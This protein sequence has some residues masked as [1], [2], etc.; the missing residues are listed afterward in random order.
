VTS[1]AWANDNR[2]IIYGQEDATTKRS[3]KIFRHALGSEQE[4]LLY[5][6]KDELYNVYTG[7]DAQ[8]RLHRRSLGQF[9][10]ER[11]ALPVGGSSG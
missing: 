6:E 5:E 4:E 9:D 8:Q 3:H 10:H 7:Q 11:S 2:T 1:V